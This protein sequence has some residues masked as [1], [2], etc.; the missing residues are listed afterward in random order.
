VAS[1]IKIPPLST[2]ILCLTW[3]RC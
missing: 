1:F 2:E 3:N